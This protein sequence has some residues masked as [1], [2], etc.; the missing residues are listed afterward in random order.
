MIAAIWLSTMRLCC[1]NA[2]ARRCSAELTCS[3][4]CI[5]QSWGPSK[6]SHH[7]LCHALCAPSCPLQLHQ[8][9]RM[10]HG[11]IAL[12]ACCCLST[13]GHLSTIGAWVCLL[14]ACYDH[15]AHPIRH[16]RGAPH[17]LLAGWQQGLATAASAYCHSTGRTVC[18]IPCQCKDAKGIKGALP[19]AC[20]HARAC[21]GRLE[22]T[23][24]AVRARAAPCPTT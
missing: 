4:P 11:L 10:T 9:A 14:P 23:A 3:P 24:R 5:A 20:L 22:V 21:A 18:A 8:R 19:I 6:R 15:L 1:H 17:Q 16:G 7:A 2:A 13:I 12:P